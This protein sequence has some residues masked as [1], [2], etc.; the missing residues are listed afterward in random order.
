M[1]QN[2]LERAWLK[3]FINS[4]F[5]EIRPTQETILLNHEVAEAITKTGMKLTQELK[6]KITNYFN[7]VDPEEL[8]DECINEYGMKEIKMRKPVR[9]KRKKKLE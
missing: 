9:I 7:N 1:N 5:G 4:S 2:N 8:F 3:I 6:D